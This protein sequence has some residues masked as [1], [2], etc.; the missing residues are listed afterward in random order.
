MQNHHVCTSQLSQPGD[1]ADIAA[2]SS[3]CPADMHR[4]LVSIR[5]GFGTRED[6]FGGQ[7]AGLHAHSE[8]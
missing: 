7:A 8:P 4:L 6:S 2:Q 3:Q 1:I 5:Q